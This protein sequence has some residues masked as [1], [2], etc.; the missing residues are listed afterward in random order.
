MSSS[1]ALVRVPGQ[2]R[3][4]WLSWG[5]KGCVLCALSVLPGRSGTPSRTYL[6]GLDLDPN[7]F[8]KYRLQW[9]RL[10][11]P[12][13]CQPT[14]RSLSFFLGPLCRTRRREHPLFFRVF[15]DLN[16]SPNHSDLV[17]RVPTGP[18]HSSPVH[19]VSG[20]PRPTQYYEP[21]L[22]Y[23]VKFVSPV[24]ESSRSTCFS[25]TNTECLVK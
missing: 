8:Q 13:L 25:V 6:S 19:H 1:R 2:R 11:S 23:F 15:D 9:S 10:S 7:L 3:S 12:T 17:P 18:F 24:Q 5:V 20:P 16:L 21:C 14:C 22:G 4:W